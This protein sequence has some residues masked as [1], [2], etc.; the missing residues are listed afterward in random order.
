M[1]SAQQYPFEWQPC[2]L[3]C[4]ADTLRELAR[5]LAAVSAQLVDL[6][7]SGLKVQQGTILDGFPNGGLQNPR[8]G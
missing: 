3:R 2:L 5:G 8:M 4:S 1:I 6:A 7:G